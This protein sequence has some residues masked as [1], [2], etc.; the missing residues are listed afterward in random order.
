MRFSNILAPPDCGVFFVRQSSA[1]VATMRYL[2]GVMPR[3]EFVAAATA[4]VMAFSLAGCA[5]VMPSMPGW[6]TPN[7]M[8]SKSSVP[9]MPLRFESDPPGAEVRTAQGQ[10]CKT[11][12]ELMVPSEPQPV[13]VAKKGF[14]TQTVQVS[15]GDPPKHSFW[16][17]PPPALMPNPV[18]A[19]LT[20]L[21]HPAQPA[22][23]QQ[24]GAGSAAR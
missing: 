12:C 18:Q 14:V 16:E 1:K 13:S 3:F 8:T 7:W 10:T 9:P 11:P 2:R 24:E 4:T 20:P 6:M 19:I 21:R 5:S 23:V 22:K 17:N 15:N